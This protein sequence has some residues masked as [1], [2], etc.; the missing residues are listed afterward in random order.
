MKASSPVALRKRAAK[1]LGELHNMS[2]TP[3]IGMIKDMYCFF[4]EICVRLE[5]QEKEILECQ[6]KNPTN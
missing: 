1:R 5:R 2:G 4:K 6:K 3:T